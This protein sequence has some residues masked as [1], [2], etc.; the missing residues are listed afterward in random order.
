MNEQ[1]IEAIRYLV[2]RSEAPDPPRAGGHPEDIRDDWDSY[3]EESDRYAMMKERAQKALASRGV[4]LQE[5]VGKWSLA[6]FGPGIRLKEHV[7]HMRRELIEL[8][9]TLG[10]DR[11]AAENE[12]ADVYILLMGLANRVGVDLE[13]AAEKKF[14]EVQRRKWKAPDADGVVEHVKLERIEI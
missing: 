7:E 14:K 5:R 1:D 12:M 9:A 4:P 13:V 10:M 6:T 3:R 8:Q 2:D 11:E